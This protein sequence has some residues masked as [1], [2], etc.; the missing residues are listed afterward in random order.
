M[1]LML[2]SIFKF[3]LTKCKISIVI[4]AKKIY[5]KLYKKKKSTKTAKIIYITQ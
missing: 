5:L 4:I 3:I 1:R 2:I